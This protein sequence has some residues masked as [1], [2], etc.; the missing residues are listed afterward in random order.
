[1]AVSDL[2]MGFTACILE[3]KDICKWTVITCVQYLDHYP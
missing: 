3:E 1:M 2:K